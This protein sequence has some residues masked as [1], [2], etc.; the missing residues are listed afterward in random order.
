LTLGLGDITST[1]P[2]ARFFMILESGTGFIFLGL[3]ISYVPLLHQAYGLREVGNMLLHSR[4][5]H[6]I[7]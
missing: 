7:W 2:V 3:M 4:T 6:P 5:G 1:D